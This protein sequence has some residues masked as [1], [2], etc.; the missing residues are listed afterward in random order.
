MYILYRRR[1]ATFSKVFCA[2]EPIEP[3]AFE[4]CHDHCPSFIVIVSNIPHSNIHLS[5][6]HLWSSYRH[7]YHRVTY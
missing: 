1:R 7:I 2:K 3:G 5:F 6:H 4:D